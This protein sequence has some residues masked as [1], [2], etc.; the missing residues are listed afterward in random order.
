MDEI[1]NEEIS[2]E[3]EE[4]DFVGEDAMDL[5]TSLL[6]KPIDDR[7]SAEEALD[8]S[9]VCSAFSRYKTT[10]LSVKVKTNIKKINAR[11]RFKKG[12]NAVIAATKFSK[13]LSLQ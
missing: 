5:C 12:V 6:K 2:F 11:K 3:Y 13:L 8:H 1:R 4:F 10:N 7:L 9:F